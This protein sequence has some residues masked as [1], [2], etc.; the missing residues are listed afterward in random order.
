MES[1]PIYYIHA[2][3]GV[4]IEPTDFSNAKHHFY[5]IGEAKHSLATC[6]TNPEDCTIRDADGK[7]LF[8]NEG[9]GSFPPMQNIGGGRRHSIW[10]KLAVEHI[11]PGMYIRCG[12]DG[13]LCSDQWAREGIVETVTSY[14]IT[15]VPDTDPNQPHEVDFVFIMSL[16]YAYPVTPPYC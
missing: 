5:T 16:G 15:F 6:C 9:E 14:K 1:N 10:D 8:T 2:P 3:N 4:R 13:G 12:F 11:K 7:I